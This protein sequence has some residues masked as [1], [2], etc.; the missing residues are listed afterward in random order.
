MIHPS[1]SNDDANPMVEMS[2]EMAGKATIRD[3][4]DSRSTY[5]VKGKFQDET[6]AARVG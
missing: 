5:E 6:W 3:T 1:E 2:F 4:T